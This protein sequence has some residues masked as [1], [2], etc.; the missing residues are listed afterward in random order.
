ML[1]TGIIQTIRVKLVTHT[2]KY[3]LWHSRKSSNPHFKNVFLW[4]LRWQGAQLENCLR[5]RYLTWDKFH[6][7]LQAFF[8]GAR[9][10]CKQHHKVN[11]FLAE[12]HQVTQP[13]RPQHC[14]T[15]RTVLVREHW[16][17][18]ASVGTS[19]KYSDVSSSKSHQLNGNVRGLVCKRK[20]VS[21]WAPGSHRKRNLWNLHCYSPK[22]HEVYVLFITKL[23]Q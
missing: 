16:K 7:L 2:T 15:V 19:L 4:V 17:S 1:W 6:I 20:L 13:R 9:F 10:L 18:A 12:G 14:E 21:F 23:L 11:S 5:W 8:F 22:R 3:V